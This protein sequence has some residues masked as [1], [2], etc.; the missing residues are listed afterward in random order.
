MANHLSMDK[1]C[2]IQHLHAQGWSQRRIAEALGV[3]RKTIRRYLRQATARS[4]KHQSTP[5]EAK[6][7]SAPTGS[8]PGYAATATSVTESE[9]KP[10]DEAESSAEVTARES[11]PTGSLSQCE[12]F[13][14]TIEAKLRGGLSAQRIF[15][16][17]QTESAFDGSYYSVRRFV[18]K[19]V[20]TQPQAFRRIE[21]APVGKFKSTSAP[22][23]RSSTPRENVERRMCFASS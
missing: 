3:D 16:D 6:G 23:P 10:N 18:H 2:S 9:D 11:G 12:P 21:V 15:Q 14:A 22:A 8:E 20:F 1:A 13:L 5:I 19:L 17:L 7:T 4:G